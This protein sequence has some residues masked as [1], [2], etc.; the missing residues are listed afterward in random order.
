LEPAPDL[1]GLVG[2]RAVDLRDRGLSSRERDRLQA[3]R[4]LDETDGLGV[5]AMALPVP[6]QTYP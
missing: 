3:E 5:E 6:P 2:Y 4:W 1:A